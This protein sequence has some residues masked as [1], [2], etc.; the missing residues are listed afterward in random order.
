[1]DRRAFLSLSLTG[2]L[3]G[4]ISE[5]V[6][7]TTWFPQEFTCPNCKT[8]NT[9]NVIGSYGTYIYAWPSKYQSIYWPVT[10]ENVLYSCKK[11]Y[12]SVFMWDFDDL[13]KDK[14]LD[15]QKQ[16]VGVKIEGTYKSYSQIPMSRRL[17]VAEKIYAVLGM[18]D[19]FW[20]RFYR[21]KGYHFEA[22]KNQQK[23]DEARTKALELA[24]KMLKDPKNKEPQKQLLFITGAM[25][26]FL[27]DD[28][29]AIAELQ[30][31]LATKYTNPQLDA[32]KN[33]NGERNLNE[34]A[35][36]YIDKIK[37]PQKPRLMKE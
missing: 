9:F 8:K 30:K 32:E 14:L 12:L 15:I 3:A 20:C 6:F 25:K 7:A 28:D 19:E 24:N 5:D 34:L 11:C 4:I 36:E 22:E 35:K 10:D 23:A 13:P 33:N 1:M 29:G 31:V 37:S 16:L 17:E 21:I 2:V 26:H 18:E 27:R